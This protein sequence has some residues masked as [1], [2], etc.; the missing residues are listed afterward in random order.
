MNV[1][2][3][4]IVKL[5]VSFSIHVKLIMSNKNDKFYNILLEWL[6]Q[7][8]LHS[9]WVEHGLIKILAL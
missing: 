9:N 5:F 7:P 6:L 4:Y 8:V 1:T 2:S 3:E